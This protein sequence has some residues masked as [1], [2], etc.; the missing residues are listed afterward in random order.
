MFIGGESSMAYTKEQFTIT[1][2]AGGNNAKRKTKF[3][4]EF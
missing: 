1:S 3:A 4:F 2:L